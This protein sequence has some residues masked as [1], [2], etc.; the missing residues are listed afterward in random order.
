MAQSRCG[1]RLAC[2]DAR[3]PPHRRLRL[4]APAGADRPDAARAARREPAD[5]R[6]PR[7]A[8][9]SS[10][11]R[12][13]TSP[14]CSQPATCSSSTAR[15]S[16]GRGC[17]ARASAPARRAEIFLLSPARRRPLRG[18]GVAGRQAQAGPHASRSRR[19]SPSRSSSSPSAARASSSSRAERRRSS[20]RSSARP[21][22][23]AAVHR[24]ACDEA[25]DVERY[26]TVYAREAGSVAAPTAGLH[27]TPELLARDRRARRASRRGGAARRRR[28]VQAGGGRGSGRARDARGVVHVPDETARRARTR[29]RATAAASGRWARRPCARWRARCDD[30]GRVRAGSGETR[31]FI[32]PPARFR[33]V[34]ALVTNF[35][36]PRSTLIM[37]VAAFAGYD[38]TMRAY[39]E[40]IAERL[41]LLLVRRRDGDRL[42]AMPVSFDFTLETTSGAARAGASRTPHGVVETPAFMAGRHARHG[43]GARPRRPARDAA[44]R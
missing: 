39:R 33:A 20:R 19:A 43:E 37:L 25:A 31:I 27:F 16:F 6:R 24:R 44:R 13:P 14:T 32:R 41:S 10:T 38:L 8:A 28:H 5:G 35:H 12:S 30:D 3:G 29:A 23:A 11:A 34:D 42:T 36:L 18:D 4:R 17:S 21:H 22:P 40:A 2:R 15:A 1:R 9:R 26:Q 7:D